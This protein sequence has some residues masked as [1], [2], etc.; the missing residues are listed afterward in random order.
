MFECVYVFIPHCSTPFCPV[1]VKNPG[2]WSVLFFFHNTQTSS[3]EFNHQPTL[4]WEMASRE[5]TC[6]NKRCRGLGAAWVT[7]GE[8]A[9]G[10]EGRDVGQDWKG[11]RDCCEPLFANT[12]QMEV[13]VRTHRV[14]DTF[15]TPAKYSGSHRCCTTQAAAA[16]GWLSHP[17]RK[18]SRLRIKSEL[19]VTQAALHQRS[20]AV[21]E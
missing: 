12:A 4:R 13:A 14:A 21:V 9:R 16:T 2:R 18:L 6:V 10:V 19:S 15:L 17:K 11:S 20:E 7:P 3:E 8:E 5:A 1:S